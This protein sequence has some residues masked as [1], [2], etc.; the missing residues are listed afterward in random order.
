MG[1][2]GNNGE[3]RLGLGGKERV[4]KL[5]VAAFRLILEAVGLDKI[6]KDA[7]DAPM[8][9]IWAG[10][11]VVK[12]HDNALPD[13]FSLETVIEWVDDLDTDIALELETK[14]WE[15][16]GFQ[17]GV[18][19]ERRNRA[20]MIVEGNPIMRKDQETMQAMMREV[21]KEG[22]VNTLTEELRKNSLTGSKSEQATV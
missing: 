19:S 4:I 2:Q 10:L 3:Y 6:L 13:N 16:L 22:I 20:N 17:M 8:W 1:L 21:L 14:A 11:K 18:F 12:N 5:G 7:Y 15:D 9:F